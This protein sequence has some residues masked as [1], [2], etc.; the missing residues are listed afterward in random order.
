MS[1]NEARPRRVGR[2]LIVEFVGTP[3]SGKTTLSSEL[4]GLLQEHGIEAA[5]IIGGARVHAARTLPGRAIARL[6]PYS[7]R[8]PLLWQV[9]Y[10]LSI[11]HALGFS[12]DHPSLTWQVLRTQIGRPIPTAA[13]RHILIWF[14]QLA[15]RH[16]FLTGTA[17]ASEALVLDDGFL[18]R[19]VHLNASHLEEPDAAQ[20]AAYVDLLSQPDLV[21][22]TMAGKE[23]CERRVRARG[24]WPQRRHL[25]A[26]ELSR[27]LG[28]AERVAD[29]AVRRARECGW[30]VIEVDNED[31]D[32]DRIKSDLRAALEPFLAGRSSERRSETGGIR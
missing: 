11:L 4:V 8:R 2:P 22:F 24:V 7:L 23:V 21:V 27:Y 31:R 14:F 12:R 13:K 17:R 6:A 26:T 9:F 32:L 19:S 30:T 20:V 10:L 5:T 25:S 3:G 29:E 15:G 18:H 1:S 28:N 16:R